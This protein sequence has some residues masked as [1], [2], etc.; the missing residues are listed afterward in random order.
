MIPFLFDGVELKHVIVDQRW[1]SRRKLAVN[2]REYNKDLSDKVIG[3]LTDENEQILVCFSV[4]VFVETGH[5][6]CLGNKMCILCDFCGYK[7]HFRTMTIAAKVCP[8]LWAKFTFN[9]CSF[10]VNFYYSI[11]VSYQRK[12]RHLQINH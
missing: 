7:S 3:K 11:R 5:R 4:N 9:I 1:S 2:T 10:L 6:D 8:N 12:P